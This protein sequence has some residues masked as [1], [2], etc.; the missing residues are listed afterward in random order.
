MYL[1][2]GGHDRDYYFVLTDIPITHLPSSHLPW[3][4]EEIISLV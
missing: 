3:L 2:L 4:R 1:K